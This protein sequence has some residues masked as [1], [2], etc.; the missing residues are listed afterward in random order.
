MSRPE[1]IR[2]ESEAASAEE[3]PADA[4]GLEHVTSPIDE[5]VAESVNAALPDE[6][7]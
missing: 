7:E 5:D 3:G 4:E 1:E 2:T 6:D